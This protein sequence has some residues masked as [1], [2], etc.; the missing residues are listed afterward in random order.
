MDELKEIAREK[1]R[2]RAENLLFVNEFPEIIRELYGSTPSSDRGLR[3]IVSHI[4]AQQGRTVIDSP[5]LSASIVEIGEFGLDILREAV[6]NGNE[7]VEEASAKNAA[8]QRKVKDKKGQIGAIKTILTK[9]V[10]EIEA[11]S[12]S[13]SR[14]LW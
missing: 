3:D 11:D 12:V 7:R 1:F 4:C 8:L 5:D 2:S 9:L 13:E 14:M 6:M 10:H